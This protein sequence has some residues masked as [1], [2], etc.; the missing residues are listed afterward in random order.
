[1]TKHP[2]AYGLPLHTT[3]S[4]LR[5]ILLSAPFCNFLVFVSLLSTTVSLTLTFFTVPSQLQSFAESKDEF[6]R[7]VDVMR[8]RVE[9]HRW[10]PQRIDDIAR[11]ERSSETHYIFSSDTEAMLPKPKKTR[12]RATQK[13]METSDEGN[14][15]DAITLSPPNSDCQGPPGLPGTNGWNGVD[16]A[17]GLDGSAGLDGT[18]DYF[19]DGCLVCHPGEAGRPGP[20]GESGPDGEKGRG[21]ENGQDGENGTAGTPGTERGDMGVQ[22]ERGPNGSPGL[23]AP[24][25]VTGKGAPGPPG[26]P[27]TL[28]KRGNAGRVGNPTVTI[29][30]PGPQG[31][32]GEP[33]DDGLQGE[34]GEDGQAGAPGSDTE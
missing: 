4:R 21:G 24:N 25:I 14:S 3:T 20:P 26:P 7:K 5:R 34:P 13:I 28:G 11:L 30:A 2:I 19:E 10:Q 29:G 31:T 15:A 33:G 32:P 8:K 27:G 17:P 18:L 6:K 16:G 22:G 1:M 23:P 9:E 12:V